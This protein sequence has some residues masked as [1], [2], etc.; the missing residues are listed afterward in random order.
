MSKKQK[1]RRKRS[2]ENEKKKDDGIIRRQFIGHRIESQQTYERHKQQKKELIN[3]RFG[4]NENKQNEID[5]DIDHDKDGDNKRKKKNKHKTEQKPHINLVVIGHVDAGKSTLMGR[6]LYEYG[7]VENKTMHKYKKESQQS[8]KSSFAYAWV[9]DCHEEERKRG[10]T[11]D[12][13]THYFETEHRCITLLDSPG[14]KDFIP[15]MISGASQADAAILVINSKKG[16]FETGFDINNG[17]T[18]EHALIAKSLGV[19]QIIV[20]VNKMDCC[21]W[22]K[23]RFDMIVDQL[24]DFLKEIGFVNKGKSKKKRNVI[25]IPVSGLTGGN[26]INDDAKKDNNADDEIMNKIK[27]KWWKKEINDPYHTNLSLFEVID[28]LRPS[29]TILNDSLNGRLRM[30]ITDI[31]KEL[32]VGIVATGKILSGSV[33]CYEQIL[34]QPLN[35]VTKIKNLIS[36]DNHSHKYRHKIAIKGDNIQLLLDIKDNNDEIF[37]QIKIGDIITSPHEP[38]KLINR[39]SCKIVTMKNLKIPICKGHHVII[40]TQSVEKP[41][42]IYKINNMLNKKTG[43]IEESDK[44]GKKHKNIRHI[45][46]DKCA[47]VTIKLQNK[48]DIIL[49]DTYQNLKE[50][51]RITIRRDGQ[52]IALGLVETV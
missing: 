46:A 8:G 15:N 22:N 11:V 3:L 39:F 43:Q 29:S 20:A 38:L 35:L 28:R 17:Q 44:S 10:I 47:I 18:R 32:N 52:T 27:D 9:L 36:I 30:S 45:K 37:D 21:D 42:Y 5:R 50:L 51:G 34:I 6:L 41:A 4:I 33:M 1:K 40:H 24:K 7:I 2:H 13:S 31:Y 25:F 12:V 19:Q 23:K 48:N 16:D 26:L 14:H 49:L